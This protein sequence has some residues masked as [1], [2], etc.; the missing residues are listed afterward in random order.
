VLVGTIVPPV[1]LRTTCRVDP[2][3]VCPPVGDT[4]ST[5]AVVDGR[6]ATGFALLLPQAAPR[7]ASTMATRATKRNVTELRTGADR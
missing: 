2:V 3:T 5:V 7:N 6:W 1:S 4:I